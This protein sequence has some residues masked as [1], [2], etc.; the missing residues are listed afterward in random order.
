MLDHIT[1]GMVRTIISHMVATT[2]TMLPLAMEVIS[3]V[4]RESSIISRAWASQPFG[5]L[6]SFKIWRIHI[7]VMV[8]SI[9]L[10]LINDLELLKRYHCCGVAVVVVVVVAVVVADMILSP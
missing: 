5:F 3:K 9:S 1:C 7:T 2:C 10:C 8:K 6:L 4:S